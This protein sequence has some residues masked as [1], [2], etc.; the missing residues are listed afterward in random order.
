MKNKV[1]KGILAILVVGTSGI[2]I[3]AMESSIDK[4]E[5]S[6]EGISLSQFTKNASSSLKLRLL[7]FKIP[8]L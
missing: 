3:A 6:A 1:L 4:I 7:N 8:I 5:E 2:K